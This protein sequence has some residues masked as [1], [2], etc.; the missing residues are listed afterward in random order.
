[1]PGRGI[2]KGAVW[3]SGWRHGGETGRLVLV[4]WPLCCPV[5]LIKASLHSLCVPAGMWCM[6]GGNKTTLI[7]KRLS[8]TVRPLKLCVWVVSISHFLWGVVILSHEDLSLCNVIMVLPRKGWNLL[9]SLG[10][11]WHVSCVKAFIICKH[12]RADECE[13]GHFKVCC[14]SAFDY[15]RVLKI[16]KKALFSLCLSL[17]VS[18]KTL[19]S[20]LE[21]AVKGRMRREWQPMN[22]KPHDELWHVDCLTVDCLL[23]YIRSGE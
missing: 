12:A 10:S 14:L 20:F 22:I 18:L 17:F 4:C 11:F 8:E 15:S 7:V 23:I 13:W 3:R 16:W 6:R 9:F 19:V 2:N 21:G 1:M 5:W